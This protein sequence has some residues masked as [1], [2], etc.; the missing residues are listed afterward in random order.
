VSAIKRLSIP[1]VIDDFVAYYLRPEN[2]VWGSLHIVLDDGNIGD[3]NLEDA[4]EW[5]KQRNDPEGERLAKLMML[6]SRSQRSRL[7]RKVYE[8][9]IKLTTVCGRTLNT[10]W[11][12]R[13]WLTS[14][15]LKD[16]PC[17]P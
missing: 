5:A 10:E 3:G 9:M 7:S 15:W 6:M 2:S 12:R 8:R 4:I 17:A 1:E 16:R 11:E 13:E 14:F